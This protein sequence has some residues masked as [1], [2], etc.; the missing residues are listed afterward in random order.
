MQEDAS[1]RVLLRREQDHVELRAANDDDRDGD[2]CRCQ[3]ASH[4]WR[5]VCQSVGGNFLDLN[6]NK[7]HRQRTV[8]IGKMTLRLKHGTETVLLREKPTTLQQLVDGVRK[9]FSFKNQEVCLAPQRLVALR[10]G[11]ASRRPSLCFH[12]SFDLSAWFAT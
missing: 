11:L 2:D 9:A 7:R 5:V 3:H 10:I 6:E 4:C 1:E 12:L 8:T